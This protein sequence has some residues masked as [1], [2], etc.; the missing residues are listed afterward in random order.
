MSK[1][2]EVIVKVRGGVVQ[3]VE[4][5]AGVKVIVKDFDARENAPE[6]EVWTSE[7]SVTAISDN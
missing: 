7:D 2:K 1:D 6:I 4:C 5:P 3:Q